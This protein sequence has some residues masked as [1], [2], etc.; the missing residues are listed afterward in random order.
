MKRRDFLKHGT[1]AVAATSA[2]GVPAVLKAQDA[3]KVGHMTP[4]TGFL[5]Q[6]GAYAVMA[7]QLAVDEANAKGGVL[8]R[9]IELISEDTPNPGVAVTKAQK[10]I[11]RDRAAFLLGEISSASGLAIS[12]VAQRNKIL[13]FNTGWN[14]D[15]GRG[16]RCQRYLFHVE[17]CNT[18]YT[19]TIGRW[20]ERNFKLKE[21]RWYF[22]TA[23]Y[24]FG[25]DLYRVS[26]RFLAEHGGT[27]L[28]NDMIATNT[29]DY[30]AYILKLRTIKPDLLYLNLAGTDQTTFLKQYR[31]F[32][33]PY[34]VAGGVMDTA[35]FWAAGIDSL[36]GHWQ[37]LWYHDLKEPGSPEFVAAFTKR[38]GKPPEN[39][40]WGEYTGIRIALQAIAETKS[41]RSQDLV[42]YFEKGARFD[43]LKGREASFRDWDHQLL[44]TMY[45]VKVKDKAKMRDQWDIFDI[46]EAQPAKGDALELIQPTKAE[47]ACNMPAL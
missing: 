3:I 1:T 37:S 31:E 28:G 24:A 26:S 34:P 10:L 45:V 38:N 13:Y 9:K 6:L 30:S 23:D 14:S 5:G 17:G 15:E 33:S 41:T 12:E 35:Q 25:H 47:N 46:V 36:S 18:M 32:G 22:L 44:Q 43:V 4:R 8:G 39:Q 7:A 2:L 16:G 19:K 27:N 29:L 20:Q 21:A 11:E 40:A 42:A